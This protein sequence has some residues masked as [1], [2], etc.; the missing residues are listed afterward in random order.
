MYEMMMMSILV[1]SLYNIYYYQKMPGGL[2][3]PGPPK[4]MFFSQLKKWASKPLQARLNVRK[5]KI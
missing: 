5:A 3:P 4:A 2:R 1:S